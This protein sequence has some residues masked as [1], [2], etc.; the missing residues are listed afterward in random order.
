MA[1]LEILEY[2]DPGLRVKCAAVEEVT[3][4]IRKVLNDMAETMYSAPGVGLAAT[5]VGSIHRLIV[6]DVG[7]DEETGRKSRLFKIVN[8]V[9][10]KTEGK[11]ETEEGCLSV[12][13]I[14]EMVSRASSVVVRGLDENGKELTIEADGLLAVCLQHEIDH[15]DGILFIDH[16]SRLKQQLVKSKYNKLRREEVPGTGSGI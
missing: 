5:Q 10:T 11:T 16:L 12:P 15:L 14:R 13:G 3:D 7:S 8:P 1:L 9:I 2:P 6:A 4:E